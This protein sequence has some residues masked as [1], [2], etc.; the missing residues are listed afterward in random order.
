MKLFAKSLAIASLS[1]CA[2]AAVPAAAQVE[3]RFATLDIGRAVIGTSALQTAYQ[4]VQTTYS[5]QIET[6]RT[7]SQERQTL[8]QGFDTNG[9]N[10][11]ND[12]EL[13]AAQASPQFAQLQTLE[14]EIQQLS[15]QIDAGRIF[16]IEEILKQY[17]AALQEVVTQQQVQMVMA[18]N[19]VLYAPPAADITQQITTSLNAKVPQV[20]I[21]PPANWQPSRQGVQLFQ[22]I[23]QTLV[24]AQVLQQRQQAAQQQQQ[25][26]NAQSPQGR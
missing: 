25:Q 23:Q 12:A 10:E 22:E 17:P 8:L 7:K 1:L 18:P 9:D 20:G 3:G 19:T 14:A 15:N 4:Q 21:V 11:V 16:A 6:R 24:T 5:A 26:G 2:A 13:Q